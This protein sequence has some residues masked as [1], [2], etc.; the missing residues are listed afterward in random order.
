[1]LATLINCAAIAVTLGLS[2]RFYRVSYPA[3]VKITL[4]GILSLLFVGELR[5]WWIPYLVGTDPARVARYAAM[6]GRTHAFLPERNGM[7]PNTAHFALHV[8]TFL[9]LLLALQLSFVK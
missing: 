3:W 6:F 9:A 7:R 2:L 5:A 1:L 8:A 4:V